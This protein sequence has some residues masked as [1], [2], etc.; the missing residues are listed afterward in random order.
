MF[1][2]ILK[3]YYLWGKV[4]NMDLK[5]SAWIGKDH[6]TE[7]AELYCHKCGKVVKKCSAFE[8][9]NFVQWMNLE[10]RCKCGAK[11]WFIRDIN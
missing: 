2:R 6:V 1:V 5:A 8:M 9:E 4:Q 10:Q 11:L 7:Q 3:Q